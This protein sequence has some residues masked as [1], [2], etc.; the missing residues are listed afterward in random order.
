MPAS[1][2]NFWKFYPIV[3]GLLL[4]FV[5]V[6]V[7]VYT[8]PLSR[9]PAPIPVSQTPI[10]ADTLPPPTPTLAE[11]PVPVT[12][13]G[14]SKYGVRIRDIPSTTTNILGGIAP[15]G[16]VTILGRTEDALW[17]WVQMK[18][19]LGWVSTEFLTIDGDVQQLSI[20][21]INAK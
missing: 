13:S 17:V 6:V 11:T 2:S 9:E 21:P 20:V 8:S 4:I 3:L 19:V 1:E 10:P 7:A 16:C 18:D 12:L 15:G 14:C 5:L